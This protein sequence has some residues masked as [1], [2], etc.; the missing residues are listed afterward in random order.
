MV[1]IGCTATLMTRRVQPGCVSDSLQVDSGVSVVPIY[2]FE[3]ESCGTEFERILSFSDSS[4][5]DCPACES[6]NVVRQLS[7]PAIHFK[8]SGWY[9]NDS[10]QTAKESA[11]GADGAT[12]KSAADDSADGSSGAKEAGTSESNPKPAAKKEAATPSA[13]TSAASAA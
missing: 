4:A 7:R 10:K 11:K 3:C 2:E 1:I 13:S 9:I 12:S 5:P 8:G 6:D